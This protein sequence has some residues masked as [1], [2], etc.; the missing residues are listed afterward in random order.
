VLRVNGRSAAVRQ[1]HG[2]QRL[3]DEREERVL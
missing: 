3:D 1:E 2:R